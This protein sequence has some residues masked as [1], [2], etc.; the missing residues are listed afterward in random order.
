[1]TIEFL[2]RL[3]LFSGLEEEDL[4]RLCR[5]A[6]PLTVGAGELLIEEGAPGDALYIIVAGE[7]EV[8]KRAG[9]RE[10]VISKREPG[11][12]IGETS[13]L[14][15]SPRNASVRAL[16]DSQVF[17]IGQEA[18]Q[19]LLT[20]SPG[21]TRAIFQTMISRLRSTESLLL[22]HEKMA[23]LG[24]LAAGLAHELNNPAAAIRRGT[25]QLREQLAEWQRALVGLERLELDRAQTRAIDLLQGEIARRAAA[26]VTLDPVAWSD[27][28]SAVQAWLEQH[29]V[30]RSWVLTPAL[31]SAGWD[32]AALTVAV[33]P[34]DADQLPFILNW[35]GAGSAVH[36]LLDE[37]DKSAER[38]AEIVGAI[39]R[40]SYL[41]RA[42]I[43]QV[44]VHE[45]LDST[46][47]ILRH[48][49]QSGIN[50]I[51]DYAPDLPRIEAYAS[52]LN[53]VWT[54]LIDNAIDA[55][56]NSDQGVIVLRT[57]AQ[58]ETV[59]VEIEDNG[60]G[61]T[62]DIQRRLFE[63]FFTTKPMG[64]GTGLGLHIVYNIVVHR[65]G[66]WIQFESEPGRTCF[67]VTL[68]IRL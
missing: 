36:I 26:L 40:Y 37:V 17:K 10:V 39:K 47:V 5:M 12:M 64:V 59:V 22:Q 44:H 42:P 65:H 1:M 28:E 16:H 7:F 41:D 35:L 31:V 33:A 29:G 2:R 30:D 49:L 11:E 38:I 67:R 15:G 48:K 56:G 57:Y 21:A 60:P 24:G 54:N 9:D 63:P 18:F 62:P 8:T 66:G 53:Q 43:H 46:L 27:L 14:D 19:Q 68:P 61:I 6:E 50:V 32:L 45:G 25:G 55:V 3:S 4:D 20:S 58:R 13:L 51:R 34:F 52:E 23:A